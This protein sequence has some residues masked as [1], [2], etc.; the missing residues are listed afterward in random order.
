MAIENTERVAMKERSKVLILNKNVLVRRAIA[1]VLQM[2]ESFDPIWDSGG[3]QHVKHYISEN[4]PDVVLLSIESQT[5]DGWQLLE[6]IRSIFPKLPIGIISPRTKE[7]ATASVAAL[8]MGIVDVLTIPKDRTAILFAEN[9]LKKRLFTIVEVANNLNRNKSLSDEILDSIIH[10]QKAF[11]VFSLERD[12]KKAPEII[13]VGSG[14]GGPG[15]LFSL[16][17]SLPPDLSIPMVIVQHFPKIFTRIL[18]EALD[19]NSAIN[20]REAYDEAEL[21]SG[22]V[23]IAPGG[24]QCELER[25]GTRAFLN[26][27]HGFREHDARPCID[28]LFRSA[29]NTY[30]SKVLA[31]ILSGAIMDGISGSEEIAKAGGQV[32]VQDP[33]TSVAP[34]LPLSIIRHGLTKQYFTPEKIAQ[35]LV[36]QLKSSH[37][38]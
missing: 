4:E 36:E 29:A 10:P 11:E 13:V 25:K 34:E 6:M 17:K 21:T 5:S 26:I 7:G 16:I 28:T 2:G 24:K 1:N 22:T 31:I 19:E 32:I 38:E 27:H 14:I 18:A 20:V 15:A 8:K 9:H 30:K 23:W 12:E 35:K 37:T 33:E 3:L